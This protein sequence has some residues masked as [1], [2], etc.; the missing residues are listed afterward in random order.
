MSRTT[1]LLA[2]ILALAYLSG[3]AAI[4]RSDAMDTE[5][6]L[7]AAGFQ[8]KFARTPEQIAKANELPQRSLTPT[9]GPDGTNRFVWADATYCKCIYVG[10]EAAYDRYRKLQIKQEIAENE[11]M[12]SMNWG[13]W[14]GWGPW[15]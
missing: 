13:A 14:D 15:Y 2:V 11:E 7:A 10:T 9:P 5:R 6:S 1:T 8:M 12:A 4:Q 3:C